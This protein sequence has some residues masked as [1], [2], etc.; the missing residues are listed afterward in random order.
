MH[1]KYIFS[2]MFRIILEELQ[3]FETN[4]LFFFFLFWTVAFFTQPHTFCYY[5]YCVKP[6]ALSATTFS[7]RRW[8][9]MVWMGV[10]STGW[11]TGWMAGPKELWSVELIPAGGRSQA[12]S[13]RARYWGHFCLTSQLTILM[14]RLSAPSVSIQMTP[15]WE[16]VLI[17][18]REE[19]HYRGT[20]PQ[21]APR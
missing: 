15:S 14:R 16:G 19:G 3:K 5:I 17:C 7:W 1:H 8:L 10:R 12:V 9:P 11:N 4:K 18:L 2:G 6:L 20:W 13:P 21:V